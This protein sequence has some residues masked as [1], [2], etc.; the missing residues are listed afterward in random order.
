MKYQI[1]F[2]PPQMDLETKAV[3]KKLA[4]ANRYLGELKG[5]VPTIPNENILIN[6]LALQEA[7]D[8]S[9]IEN[10]ITT[11]DELYKSL[12]FENLFS[13]A[14]A[15]EVSRYAD[16]LKEGFQLVR[17]QKLITQ[18]TILTIQKILE[19]NDAGY[20]RL[21]GTA[22]IN[23]ATG[24]TVYTPPQD[25]DS[26]NKLMGNL[27]DFINDEHMSELDPLIKMAL[28][29]FQFETIHPFYDGNGRTGR[30]LNILYLVQQDLLD[31]PILYLSRFIIQRKGDYYRLL[32]EVR[33]KGNCE[34]WV[35]YVLEGVE[36]TAK[37]TI[38]VIGSI[39]SLMQ[40]YKQRIRSDFGKIYS[41][42]LLN[43][44]FKHPYTKIEFVMDELDVSRLTARRY[45]GLLVDAG[46]LKKRKI[47]I[48]NFY[49]NEPLYQLF[50]DGKLNIQKAEPIKTVNKG[51][52]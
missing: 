44:L 13:N 28:L 1:E 4:L 15:K 35:L 3:L 39:R 24:K 19:Q 25:F 43:N 9:A 40:D 47:G 8:S 42:D 12:L 46:Y 5:K 22:L 51:N 32:Q 52:E 30:I 33:D 23:E 45:L 11:H 48:S 31:I 10:I 17:K 16:A 21:P 29:H 27:I 18:K 41:Q 50:K 36:Q 37:E 26:I 34:E 49:I 2:L 7:K 6:T 14:A 20:R 38:E